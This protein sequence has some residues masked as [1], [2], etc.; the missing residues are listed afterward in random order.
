MN[1]IFDG[2]FF[3]NDPL[4]VMPKR[5]H[6]LRPYK[7]NRPKIILGIS[8]APYGMS[9]HNSMPVM[10]V[11]LDTGCNANF[12]IDEQHLYWTGYEKARY[13]YPLDRKVRPGKRTY[14]VFH[15]T[16]WLHLQPYNGPQFLGPNEPF[17]L[18]RSDEIRVMERI[19]PEPA[20]RFPLLGLK[21]LVLNRLQI[22]IDAASSHFHIYE[23]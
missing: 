3:P 1:P 12:E 10:P 14:E 16:C 2:S 20:P 15:S 7:V 23:H 9:F 21:A 8:V 22:S 19:G 6:G 17:Q 4:Y 13:G 18:A 11:L 5:G